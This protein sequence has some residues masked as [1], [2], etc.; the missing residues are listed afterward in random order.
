MNESEAA[1]VLGSIKS[2]KKAAASRKNGKKGGRPRGGGA[3]T[4]SDASPS[5]PAILTHHE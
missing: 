4:S 3:D 5:N 1:R 2:E